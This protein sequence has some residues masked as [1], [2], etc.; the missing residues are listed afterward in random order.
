MSNEMLMMELPEFVELL[1]DDELNTT[2][3]EIVFDATLRWIKH[4]PKNRKCHLANL[5]N[6]CR[7]GL[8]STKVFRNKI[9][10][11][12]QSQIRENLNL[13]G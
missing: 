7:F 12:L 4:D 3:E 2:N 9:K 1:S 6:C 8:L 5:L 13:N 10:V 11:W